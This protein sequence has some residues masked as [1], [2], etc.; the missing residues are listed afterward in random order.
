L[1]AGVY[2][3]ALKQQMA[4]MIPTRIRANWSLSMPDLTSDGKL[5]VEE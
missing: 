1:S 5:E 2:A 4:E 3:A